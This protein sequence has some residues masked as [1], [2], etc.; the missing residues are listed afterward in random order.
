MS[1]V[2][3]LVFEQGG[4]V[5]G[6]IAISGPSIR[7]DIKHLEWLRDVALDHTTKLSRTRGGLG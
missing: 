7:F 1:C 5:P 3:V 6:G 2:A 4:D